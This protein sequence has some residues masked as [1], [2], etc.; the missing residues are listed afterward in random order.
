M[1]A[2]CFPSVYR[3]ATQEWSYLQDFMPEPEEISD[4]PLGLIPGT[5]YHQATASL[6]PGDLL[7]LY[8][9][10]INEAQDEDGNQLGLDGLLA[11]ARCLPATSATVAGEALMAAVAR[12]RGDR[13]RERRRDS[14]GPSMRRRGMTGF[15]AQ[16]A[17]AIQTS[18]LA[19][20]SVALAMGGALFLDRFFARDVEVPLFLF[21]VAISAWYGRTI[22]RPAGAGPF[23]CDVRL[24]F[25]STFTHFVDFHFRLT[26]LRDLRGAR[27]AGHMVHR[28]STRNRRSS[29][30]PAAGRNGSGGTDRTGKPPESYT[31]HRLKRRPLLRLVW[32]NAV[33]LLGVEDG[34][35]AVDQPLAGDSPPV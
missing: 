31:R 25:C 33:N 35:H 34:V 30:A 18:G 32:R 17:S 12:F 1:P 28:H 3:V 22:G 5:N 9:D 21:A 29:G 13:T 20:I 15:R 14:G 11:I 27:F 2:T 7:V 19:V 8:T 16:F 24:L 26:L 6:A 23:L 10:G 4:L